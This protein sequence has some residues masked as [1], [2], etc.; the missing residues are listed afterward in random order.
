[1]N[2]LVNVHIDPIIQSEHSF[3]MWDGIALINGELFVNPALAHTGDFLHEV[4]HLVTMPAE[5]RSQASGKF[6]END[7]IDLQVELSNAALF[8]N[9]GD[10]N[11]ATYWAFAACRKMGLPD[12]LPF[13]NGFGDDSQDCL[14]MCRLGINNPV[15]SAFSC[16]LYYA[17][18]LAN[19]GDEF[20]V[21]W[22][23]LLKDKVLAHA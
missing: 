4:G 3:A 6:D 10:D 8:S 23:V 13:E 7:F 5:L 16:Q 19:K 18:L 14:E 15:G 1:M 12:E 11:A 17:G 22:D 9:P 20:P 2:T 21:A